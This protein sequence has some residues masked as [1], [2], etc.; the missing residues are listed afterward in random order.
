M[1]LLLFHGQ[2]LLLSE[3]T[4]LLKAKITIAVQKGCC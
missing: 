2:L 4:E 3:L 1:S